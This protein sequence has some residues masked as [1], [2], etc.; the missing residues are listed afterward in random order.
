MKALRFHQYGPP[1]VL[2]MEDLPSPSIA[3][4]DALIQ[5][6]ASSINPSDIGIVAG[7]FKSPLPNTPGRDFAGVVVQDHVQGNGWE[8]KQVWGSGSGF[9]VTRPGAHAE[10]VVVPTMWLSEKPET[11]TM[12]QAA[13]IG[14]PYLAAWQSLV[15]VGQLQPDER[16]LIT[17]S[18]GAVGRAATQLAHWRKAFVIGADITDAATD[19][20]VF[21][22][23]KQKDLQTEIHAATQGKLVDLVLDTVGASLFESCLRALRPGGRQIAIASAAKAQ[24]EFNLVDFYHNQSR[25]FG[26]DTMKGTGPEIAAR[27]DQLRR[28]FDTGSLH[29]PAIQISDFASAVE[30]YTSVAERKTLEKQVLTMTGKPAGLERV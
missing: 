25:L 30:V 15:E 2:S 20:D 29:A 17:G 7:R 26:L 28:L 1:S 3:P 4:G 19:A 12:E 9:G 24:V 18:N 21:I 8:G 23:L 14:V 10:F 5:V 27:M 13:A 22:N 11:L 16:I 6:K